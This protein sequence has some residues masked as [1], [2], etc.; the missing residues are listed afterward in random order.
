VDDNDTGP[1]ACT[2]SMDGL[3]DALSVAVSPDGNSVYVASRLDDAVSRLDRNPTTGALTPQGCVEDNDGGSGPDAC[4]QSMDGLDGAASVAVSSD[5]KSVYVA[6]QNDSAIARLDRDPATGALTPQ[7]CVDDN[8]SGPDTCADSMDGLNWAWSVAV[9]PDGNSVYVSS[10][11]DDAVARLDR[12]PDTG[13]LTPQ[14]CVD[15]ND[16][17]LDSCGQSMD[18]LDIAQSVTVSPD[19][20]SVYVA[21]LFDD[22]IARLDRDPATGSLTPQ[23]CVDDND[24]GQ[25]ADAC[26]QSMDGLDYASSVV[27]SPDNESVYVASQHD[28]SIARL[29]RN[30]VTGA[31]T[32]HGCVDDNDSG[33][34]TC[35]QSMDGLGEATSVVTSPNGKSLYAAGIGDDSVA[36]LDR[37]L[38]DITPPQTTINSGPPALTTDSTPTFGFSS[39][40]ELSTFECRAFPSTGAAPSFGACSGSG[41]HTSNALADGAYTFEVRAT[42]SANNTDQTPAARTFKLDTMAPETTI[43]GPSKTKNRRPSFTLASSETGSSFRCKI[44]GGGFASCTSP[45]RPRLSPGRRTIQVQATD[46]AGNTDPSP[47]T[48]TVKVKKPR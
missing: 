4:T 12:D 22:A 2:Q 48:K 35:A 9:S 8:D 27:V 17:G 29:D 30:L 34:D 40:E 37:D 24:P 15:D 36:W 19:G 5:G 20:K 43:S 47:A 11:A 7:G 44:G 21:G 46:Q 14:G 31:L 23:G 26:A 25:G 10:F 41:T 32:P 33:P 6:S 42:D 1:D 18:G 39:G 16:T 13:A 45:F 38:E 3:D 28:D